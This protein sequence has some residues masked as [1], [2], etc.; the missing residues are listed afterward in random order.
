MNRLILLDTSS[1][2]YRAYHA[3]PN[4]T[5]RTGQPTGALRGLAAM[6]RKLET[7][8]PATHRAAI[9]DAHGPTHR[10]HLYPSYKANR[11]PTPPPLVA[12]IPLLHQ[13][14]PLMGWPLLLQPG[15]E[16]DDL[17][18]TLTDQA[19]TRGWSILIVTGDK[20]LTQLVAPDTLWLDTLR[21]EL[22]DEAGV[23]AKFGVPPRLIPD[24]LALIGDAVDNIPGLPGCGPKTAA[25]WLN[26]YGSLEALL[27]AA[28]TIP[29]KIGENLRAH[30]AWLPTAKALNT[31]RRDLPL[32]VTLDDLIIHPLDWPSL[33]S[34]LEQLEFRTLIAEYEK[35]RSSS[36]FSPHNDP[37]S[38][39]PPPLPAPSV[40]FPSSPSPSPPISPDPTLSSSPPAPSTA[41]L[42]ETPEQAA[43]RRDRYGCIQT[44]EALLNLAQRLAVAARTQ[45]PVAF[46]TETDGLDPRTARLIGCSFALA[47]GEAYYIPIAHRQPEG[48]QIPLSLIH[49][50]LS[51]WFTDPSAPKIAQ[52][53]KFDLHILAA[54][55]ITV[56]GL[57]HDTL[58]IDHLLASDR[59]HDL[60]HLAQRE[61]A[62]LPLT[63]AEICGTGKRART[64]DQIDLPTATRYAAEDADL[65]LR[66]YHALA[67]KLT[68]DP[69]LER[70]YHHIERPLLSVL[71][72]METAGVQIDAQQLCQ[73]SQRFAQWL[74]D[75]EA[76]VHT[77]A[78][79][80]INLS[81]PKQI[82]QLLY[83]DLGLKPLQKTETGQA[84]TSEAALQQLLER[85]E[86]H[87]LPAQIIAAIL[88][89]RR[90]SKLKN[91]Y[92]DRLPE[93]IDPRTGRVHTTF[94]QGSVLTGRLSSS[95]P[96]LQ[97]IPVRTEEGR[98]IRR[99][100]IA[101]PGH[102]LLSADYSQIELRLMAHFANDAALIAAFHAGQDIHC[103]TAAEL[104]GK[105]PAAVTADE[106]RLAKTI[107]FGLI[108]GMGAAGLARALNISRRDADAFIHRY[109]TRY[110]GV[111]AYMERTRQAARQ[112]G[113]VQT[114]FGRRIWLRHIHAA[115]SALR[116][117]DERVAINAPMQGSAADLIKLAMIDIHA[118]L[119]Q[120]RLRSRLILQV[121]DELLLEVPEAE[122]QTVA[123]LVRHLMQTVLERHAATFH[124]PPFAVPLLVDIGI[125]RNW[126]EAH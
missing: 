18:A 10:Q 16:A 54:H 109:F 103:A 87:T 126:D 51:P 121:H 19:R 20:D 84:S 40:S 25:K 41:L 72:A 102:L 53:A 57:V 70:L 125:G 35:S 67:P 58:L 47:P 62:L 61:L 88:D 112:N 94:S 81:S 99:A 104:L 32:S 1:F 28:P 108:Y 8:Y 52:N 119:H 93:R 30:L 34:F 38:S 123:E 90:L 124:L 24:Y 66:L 11:P 4:L 49:Q 116:A 7:H 118:A 33:R 17:I 115:N 12:Q 3:M 77:L 91:T 9:L 55:G 97:N 114:L 5:T 106:R 42:L 74:Q 71:L 100:F 48:A 85:L 59:P 92:L 23:T 82:A 86:P 56:A 98:A 21:D 76:R 73:Q 96:N 6:L 69:A 63:Y 111:A 31:L 45:T 80:P 15:S 26:Q 122:H 105:S 22:L 27:A 110:P 89:H 101:P 79:R 37:A 117:A 2:L 65:T 78:A 95:E 68:Q 113:Y 39:A 43:M 75:L 44:P 36:P 120:N 14:L 64:F 29:G 60:D 83:T 107:N 46:D 50:H 13:L